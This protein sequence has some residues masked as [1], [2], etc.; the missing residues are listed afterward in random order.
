MAVVGKLRLYK[1]SHETVL[2]LTWLEKKTA[3]SSVTCFAL[4]ATSNIYKNLNK[5]ETLPRGLNFNAS[6]INDSKTYMIHTIN[7]TLTQLMDTI[8]IH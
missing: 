2:T 6:N 4:R 5:E 3:S 1:S 8:Q 7:T